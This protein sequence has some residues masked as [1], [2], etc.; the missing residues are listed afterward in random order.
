MTCGILNR[1]TEQ[2][3]LVMHIAPASKFVI[4]A[5]LTVKDTS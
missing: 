1:R 4:V 2:H 3:E 5:I